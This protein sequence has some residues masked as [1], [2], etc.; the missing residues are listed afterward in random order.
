MPKGDFK[1][2]CS[3]KTPIFM[4][5]PIPI[6]LPEGSEITRRKSNPMR[7]CLIADEG[8]ELEHSGGGCLE[9]SFIELGKVGW[10]WALA[11]FYLEGHSGETGFF[12]LRG[13]KVPGP[14]FATSSFTNHGKRRNS[15][16]AKQDPRPGILIPR[17]KYLS[18]NFICIVIEKW[19]GKCLLS[20]YFV[21]PFLGSP[22][23]NTGDKGSNV[24]NTGLT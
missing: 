15:V 18:Y 13:R 9:A 22:I 5:R 14:V 10:G 23:E 16:K 3:W 17:P 2:L 11:S 1:Y 7:E 6:I 19:Q 4:I 24:M 12:R 21:S 8:T 20:F